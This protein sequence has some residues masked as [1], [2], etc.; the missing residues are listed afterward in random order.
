[1]R[2]TFTMQSAS[3]PQVR[4]PQKMAY[5]HFGSR[6]PFPI[7]PIFF[8]QTFVMGNLT[9]ATR[10]AEG[11]RRNFVLLREINDPLSEPLLGA[12]AEALA[13]ARFNTGVRIGYR[14]DAL[15]NVTGLVR[16]L[17]DSGYHSALVF[18]FPVSTDT[19]Y[20]YALRKALDASGLM[21][22]ASVHFY[23]HT[24]P[25]SHYHRPE[26][27]AFALFHAAMVRAA[28]SIIGV[29]QAVRDN[30]VKIRVQDGGME[31]GLDPARAFVVRNGIDPHIYVIKD[32]REVSEARKDLGFAE[33]LGKI[34]SFAGR[35]DRLKGSDYLVKVL[36]HYENSTDPSESDTGFVIATS[37][38]LNVEQAS[39]PFKGLLRMQR[40]IREDRLKVVIDISKYTRGDPRFRENV[41]MMLFDFALR[42]GLQGAMEDPLFAQM[43]GGTTNVP[44]QTISDVYLHPSRSEAFGLAILEAV[45]SGTYVV[46]TPVGGIPEIITD[47]RF[48][49]LVPIES[50]KNTFVKKLIMAIC[51]S[52]KP[53]QYDRAGLEQ[54]FESY[55]D[56]SMFEQFEKAICGGMDR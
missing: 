28:D 18:H 55:T 2:N 25:D 4:M 17:A 40:L 6:F 33:G 16:G 36:E 21:S 41:E 23:L 30:F 35:M 14:I 48:G 5:L 52:T 13:K 15:E 12:K 10:Y 26:T 37:H 53:G 46:S 7:N 8:G 50:D 51:G 24:N 9:A 27:E 34:V 1:M 39:K 19:E 29:S 11:E 38:L 32:E 44:V 31:L 56:R 45:F 47:A 3:T 54:Y 42:H 20:A 43:Y 49:T 22:H